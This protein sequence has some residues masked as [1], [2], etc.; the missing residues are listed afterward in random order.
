MM[1]QI[2]GDYGCPR[3]DGQFWPLQKRFN[4]C[5]GKHINGVYFSSL[6]M[7]SIVF[8]VSGKAHDF[9]SKGPERMK[10][11]KKDSEITIDLVFAEENWRDVDKDT[12]KHDIAEKVQE[13]LRL[14]LDKAK[15]LDEI[16]DANGFNSD[17]KKAVSEFLGN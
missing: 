10:Y 5:F 3:A 2:S 17:V 12:L 13:C 16:N 6:A 8:R 15:S 4:D 11:I 9:G 14:M 7:F 1:I